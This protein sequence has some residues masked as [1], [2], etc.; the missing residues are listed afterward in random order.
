[1]RVPHL[2]NRLVSLGVL[3]G[4]ASLVLLTPLGERGA[5]GAQATFCLGFILLFGYYL[6]RMLTVLHLPAITSYILVG[7][8][9]GPYLLD[10]LSH[11]VIGSLAR[12]DDVALAIIALIAGGEMRLSV[13]RSRGP[14]LAWVIVWQI[15]FSMVGA[16]AVMFLLRGHVPGGQVLGQDLRGLAR[17]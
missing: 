13:L 17:P 16:V 15:V 2:A 1:M 7:I 11:E 4:L 5:A 6:A 9:C 12:L 3:L 10:L 14:A 8:L